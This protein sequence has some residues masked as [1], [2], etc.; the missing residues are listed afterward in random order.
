MSVK[1]DVT[2]EEFIN[3]F[4]KSDSYKNNFSREGLIALYNYLE[5]LSE[6]IGEDIE[7]DIV[8]LCCEYTEYENFGEVKKAYSN[9]KLNNILDLEEHTEVIYLD[10]KGLI[11]EDF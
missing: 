6:D 1:I 10:N 9:L 3:Y 5:Q 2:E 8:A 7:L 4:E 11:I